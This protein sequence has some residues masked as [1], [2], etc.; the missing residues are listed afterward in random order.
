MTDLFQAALPWIASLILLVCM[1]VGTAGS[2]LPA[3]PGPVLIALGA[4][5]HGAMTGFE[6]LGLWTQL[7]LLV[8]FGLS[9]A[10]QFALSAAGA[11]RYGASRYGI[12]GAGLGMLVG[13]IF[14][15]PLV[16]PFAAPFVGAFLGA[17]ALEL[18]AAQL[19]WTSP[20]PAKEP[21]TTVDADAELERVEQAAGIHAPPAEG[22]AERSG[23]AHAARAGFGAT[24]GAVLGVAAQFGLALLMS[25]LI[26]FQLARHWLGG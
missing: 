12:G 7:A 2:A 11:Q 9:Q 20:L 24:L 15:S 21:Q 3:M 13:L 23:A 25:G 1:V 10:G 16:T 8:M 17:T 22:A 6:P 5:I 19:G 14:L 26:V 4:L 18:L